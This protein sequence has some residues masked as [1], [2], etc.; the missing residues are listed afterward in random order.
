MGLMLRIMMIYFSTGMYV[1]LDFA[2]CVLE[3]LIQLRKKFI[4]AWDAIKKRRYWPS[5]AP[6][7][8]MEDHF[9]GVEVGETDA[10][11]V[12]VDGVI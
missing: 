11:Q 3:G 7:K 10:I 1:I 4:F 12:K 2:F 8:Y 9:G 5:V 6:G